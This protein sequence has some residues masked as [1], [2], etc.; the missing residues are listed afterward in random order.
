MVT[1][2]DPHPVAVCM[3]FI[4]FSRFFDI[5]FFKSHKKISS[6]TFS[7]IIFLAYN[8]LMNL[9][10]LHCNE[11]VDINGEK[12]SDVFYGIKKLENRRNLFYM[13]TFFGEELLRYCIGHYYSH[14]SKVFGNTLGRYTKADF[15]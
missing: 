2:P 4:R 5:H 13:A 10:F 1:T 15:I 9:L 6:M 14:V 11:K 3:K 7:P 12:I 8:N